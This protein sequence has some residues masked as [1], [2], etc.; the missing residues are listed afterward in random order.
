M[1]EVATA[2]RWLG[3]A[4][5]RCEEHDF[6]GPRRLALS[7]LATAHAW[8]G[9]AAAAAAAVAD[10]DRAPELAYA[11]AEQEFGRAWALVAAGDVPG[12]RAVLFAAAEIAAST[13]YRVTE[14]WLLHDVARLGDAAAVADR[15]EA[16]AAECEG[17]LA[18]AFAIHARAAAG[19]RPEPLVAAA[20]RF[21][22]IGAALLAAEAATEAAHAYQ[23]QGDRRAA[24]A[25]SAQAARLLQSCEGARTPAVATTTSFV[26]LS[27]REREIA[28]F[29]AHGETAK[30]IAARSPE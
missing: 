29:A 13:G 12:G 4:V 11:R 9:D 18:T 30:E 17:T 7:L 20:E 3:E 22:E 24:A 8:L 5:T 21:E 14:A 2:R 26:P 15:I 16:L 25:S 28:T 19:V 1:G 6:A 27:P 23:R 10:L